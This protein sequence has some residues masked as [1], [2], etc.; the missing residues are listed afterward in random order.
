MTRCQ[1]LAVGLVFGAGLHAAAAAG[2]YHLFGPPARDGMCIA[3][4]GRYGASVA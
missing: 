1:C 2:V 4:E 3:K